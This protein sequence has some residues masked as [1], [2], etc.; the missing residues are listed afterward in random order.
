[1]GSCLEQDSRCVWCRDVFVH[2]DLK[3]EDKLVTPFGLEDYSIEI[4][5]EKQP[6]VEVV[7]QDGSIKCTTNQPIKINNFDVEDSLDGWMNASELK[8]GDN[9]VTENGVSVIESISSTDG[10]ETIT[11][12]TESGCFYACSEGKPIIIH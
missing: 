4:H 1:L 8:V 12:K 10:A 6:L 11:I 3:P 2:E 5:E 7:Y 9:L